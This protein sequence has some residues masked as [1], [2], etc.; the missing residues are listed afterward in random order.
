MQNRF[1][2]ERPSS[3]E[4][5]RRQIG[6]VVT[7]NYN[8]DSRYFVDFSYRS[9]GASSFGSNKRFAPFWSA[10]IG[11]T[12]S[13]EKFIQDH[14]PQLELF[15]LRYSYGVTSALGFQPYQS[16]TTYQYDWT[17]RYRGN[18]GAIMR[19]IGNDDLRWQNTYQHN[20]GVEYFFV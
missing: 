1:A 9:D 6:I 19:G 12:V 16:L 18:I 10:G 11:W 3:T 2:R 17:S 7:A 13:Q 15:R 14:L 20:L 8:F 4:T 5:T